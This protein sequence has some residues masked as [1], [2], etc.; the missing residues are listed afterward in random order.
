M[1][2]VLE[3]LKWPTMRR[4]RVISRASIDLASME[5]E[6]AKEI[7]G[8]IFDAKPSDVEEMIRQRLEERINF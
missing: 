4:Q 8:E 1:A 5:L 3:H 2:G 6:A 7:L